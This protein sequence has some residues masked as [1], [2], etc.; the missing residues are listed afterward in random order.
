M[1][2]QQ[3]AGRV[4]DNECPKIMQ[5]Y[6]LQLV[7]AVNNLNQEKVERTQAVEE[8]KNLVVTLQEKQSEIDEL[9]KNIEIQE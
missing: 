8:N 5:F 9:C 3:W 2:G 1:W 7:V 6:N 4:D